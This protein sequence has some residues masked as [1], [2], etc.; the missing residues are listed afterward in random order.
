MYVGLG[1]YA[2]VYGSKC[3]SL[4]G[5]V[6]GLSPSNCVT[7]ISDYR[8]KQN[9]NGI[10]CTL[11][12]LKVSMYVRCVSSAAHTKAGPPGQDSQNRTARCQARSARARLSEK[13]SQVRTGRSGKVCKN[14]SL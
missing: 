5:K 12:C 6:C 8:T 10:V 7:L 11:V 2:G 13:D 14:V 9:H 1:E 4:L 3:I